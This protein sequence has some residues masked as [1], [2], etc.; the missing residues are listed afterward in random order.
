VGIDRLGDTA[1][2]AVALAD[3]G[4]RTVLITGEGSHQRTAN[5]IGAMGLFG[6]NVIAFV[7]NNSGYRPSGHWSRIRTGATLRLGTAA[8]LLKALLR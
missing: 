1:A 4:R 2:F 8:E 3:P 6:A 7:L 5:D